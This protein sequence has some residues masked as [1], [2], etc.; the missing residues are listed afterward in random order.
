[1]KEQIPCIDCI[2]LPM[3]KALIVEIQ[4]ENSFHIYYATDK[5]LL[6]CNLIKPYIMLQNIQIGTPKFD[7]NHIKKILNYLTEVY[8]NDKSNTMS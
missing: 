4:N 1:M 5:L 6:K 8:V 2:T 3:C 7:V